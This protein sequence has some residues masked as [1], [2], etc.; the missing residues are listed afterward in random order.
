LAAT[1]WEKYFREN[2]QIER[3]ERERAFAARVRGIGVLTEAVLTRLDMALLLLV[4]AT[5]SFL[6]FLVLVLRN[7]AARASAQAAEFQASAWCLWLMKGLKWAVLVIITGG[8]ALMFVAGAG[9][10]V[11]SASDFTSAAVLVGAG[12]VVLLGVVFRRRLWTWPG[13][14]ELVGSV[15]ARERRTLLVGALVVL[16]ADAVLAAQIVPLM[17]AMS[18]P[19]GMSDSNG[20]AEIVFQLERN[21]P[22][23]DTPRRRWPAAVANHMAGN[24]ERARELYGSLGSD[25]RAQKNLEAL[26]RGELVPP[27]PLTPDDV[28]ASRS[29]VHWWVWLDR[30]LRPARGDISS[31]YGDFPP[32]GIALGALTLGL[33]LILVIGVTL[34]V[35]FFGIPARHGQ[36]GSAAATGPPSPW[37]RVALTLLPGAWDIHRGKVWRG[38]VALLLGSL[39][40]FVVVARVCVATSPSTVASAPGFS[41]PAMVPF[42]AKSFPLPSPPGL[43]S[44]EEVMDYHFW[45][46]FWAYPYAKLFWL[47]SALCALLVLVYHA[48]CLPRI[49]RA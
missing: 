19:T 31:L 32:M 25:P 13:L 47:G 44:P 38:Y 17:A 36:A 18:L 7:A 12:V 9:L 42:V 24:V 48:F 23:R 41:T 15:S 45:T 16:L 35:A 34:I 10:L 26:N 46:F 5:L 11:F 29:D 37:T 43:S 4:A 49:W 2:G 27:V 20:H 21:L 39:V 14:P 30:C 33:W 3:A 6:A 40:L 8:A 28:M 22:E 1:A